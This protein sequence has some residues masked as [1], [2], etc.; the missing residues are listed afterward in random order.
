[1]SHANP[2]KRP[3][4]LFISFYYIYIY[5]FIKGRL[6]RIHKSR[7]AFLAVAEEQRATKSQSSLRDVI[8]FIAAG[9][10]LLLPLLFVVPSP[11]A[12]LW[13]S[14]ALWSWRL[15]WKILLVDTDLYAVYYYRA[16]VGTASKNGAQTERE[17]EGTTCIYR[18]G[19]LLLIHISNREQTI[20]PLIKP[21]S[22]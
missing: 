15:M 8:E 9:F 16:N 7:S 5:I 22:R 18:L 12:L 19:C 2:G 20:S 14:L 4:H 21:G 1:M 11:S 6:P 10:V 17:R 3:D 13:T